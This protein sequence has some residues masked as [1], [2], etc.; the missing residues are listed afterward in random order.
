[1]VQTEKIRTISVMRVL[2]M[3]MILSFHSLCFYTHRWWIFGGV[4]VPVWDKT[5]TLLN[6][7]DLPMFVFIAG[8]LFGHLYIKGKYREWWPFIQ[9]KACRLLIPYFFWGIFLIAAMPSLHE[10]GN[11]FT[12]ISHLW[13]LLMLFEVFAIVSPFAHFLCQKATARQAI[14]IVLGAYTLFLLYHVFSNHHAFLCIHTTLSYLPPFLIGLFC[15][16][17]KIHSHLSADLAV[18]LFLFSLVSLA[19]Y[20]YVIVP[21]P[22]FADNILQRIL[23]YAIV[24]TFFSVLNNQSFSEKFYGVIT[25]FDKLSMGIYIFNQIC[26]NALLLFPRSI[27]F[28]NQ[29]YYCGPIIFFFV[30]FF[31][32]WL[33]SYIFNKSKYIKW[34]IG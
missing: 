33:L 18:I 30:G 23:G 11:L 5:A 6:A 34:S 3:L 10:W 28:F 13:F 1:M 8:F 4:Y 22:F 32:P 21:L 16:R 19:F 26:I 31:I 17:F 9:G 27:D 12:G 20:C 2:A 7:V 14:I 25:H 24:I 15:A 29:H